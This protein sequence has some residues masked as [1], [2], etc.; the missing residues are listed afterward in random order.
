MVVS[1]PEMPEFKVYID[2]EGEVHIVKMGSNA[3]D[4]KAFFLGYTRVPVYDTGGQQI[5]N[6]EYAKRLRRHA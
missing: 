6:E 5:S 1:M 4:G 3:W 2:D